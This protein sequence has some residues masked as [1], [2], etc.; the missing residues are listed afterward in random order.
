MN[1]EVKNNEV[2]TNTV[3][4][5]ESLISNISKHGMVQ[6]ILY[7]RRVDGKDGEPKVAKILKDND[8]LHTAPMN[9]THD[10]NGCI[11]EAVTYDERSKEMFMFNNLWALSN[12]QNLIYAQ[13]VTN[14]IV[15]NTFISFCALLDNTGRNF[16]DIVDYLPIKRYVLEELNK[17]TSFGPGNTSDIFELLYRFVSDSS[18]NSFVGVY[19]DANIK[20]NDINAANNK[21]QAYCTATASQLS[22]MINSKLCAGC[23]KA[24][25]EYLLGV[26]NTPNIEFIV[27]AAYRYFNIKETEINARYE[28]Y[29]RLNTTL[30]HMIDTLMKNSV[31]HMCDEFFMYNF[32]AS[33]NY[34]YT[35]LDRQY[36]D[37]RNKKYT[38]PQLQE[39]FNIPE[40]A[41]VTEF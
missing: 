23:D 10:I 32:F 7:I 37:R 1:S 16:R 40:N 21:L 4:T 39:K 3:E 14:Y 6:P 25:T 18:D 11:A 13:E 5:K 29:Y 36:Y 2:T 26:S 41:E 30:V 35:A 31:V 34:I 38:E 9:A 15:Q 28:A 12:N 8:M 19:N 22:Q 20:D 33:F 27:K 24:L 17:P